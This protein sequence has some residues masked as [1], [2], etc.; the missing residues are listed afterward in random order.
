MLTLVSVGSFAAWWQSTF[1]DAEAGSLFAY[2]Q[3][4]GMKWGK[5]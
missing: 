1:P 2:L 4:L 3:R 5:A